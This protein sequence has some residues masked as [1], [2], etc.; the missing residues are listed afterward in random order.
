MGL[1]S[2]KKPAAQHP[3]P[4]SA[5]VLLRR[6]GFRIHS[7]P[8]FNGV[9]KGPNVWVRNGITRSEEDALRVCGEVER[10]KDG[11]T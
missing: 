4:A 7:R 1:F 10:R 9:R 5:D 3:E 6:H 11:A 8:V 2:G